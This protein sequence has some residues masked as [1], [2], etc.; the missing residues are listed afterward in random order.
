MKSRPIAAGSRRGEVLEC[1]YPEFGKIV[2]EK[3][4]RAGMKNPAASRLIGVTTEMVR[5][6]RGGFAMAEGDKLRRLAQLIGV[7]I[8]TLL[9]ADRGGATGAPRSEGRRRLTP[10]EAAMLEEFRQLP[11][12][13]QKLA[14]AR[15]IELLEEFGTPSKKNPFGKGGTQ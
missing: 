7:D 8:Q 9:M 15:I 2:D 12:E 14:R 3:L 10:D 5:R 6:Y 4:T 11:P 13:V 1:K